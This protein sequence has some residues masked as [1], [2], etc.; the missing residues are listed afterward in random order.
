M[1]VL[2]AALDDSVAARPVLAVARRIAPYLGADVVAV[3]VQEHDSGETARAAASASGVTLLAR[4]GE[5]V[6]ELEHAQHD[7][8]PEEPQ[9]GPPLAGLARP[10]QG[11]HVDS[12]IGQ[13]ARGVRHRSAAPRHGIHMRSYR[14]P[15]TWHWFMLTASR[16]TGNENFV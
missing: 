13:R 1:S 9:H 8:P 14:A 5:V 2:L 11:H 7:Q 12:R 16:D 6:S 3:H 4:Q 10:R 15:A